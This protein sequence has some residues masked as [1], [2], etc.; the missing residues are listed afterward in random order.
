MTTA[1][2]VTEVE[3]YTYKDVMRILGIGETNARKIIKSI[4]EKLEAKNKLVIR[5]KV[6]AEAF[7]KSFI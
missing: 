7:R 3:F 1:K 6:N 4:N 2:D 5:G